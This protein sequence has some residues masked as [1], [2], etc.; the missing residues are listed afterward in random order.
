MTDIFEANQIIRDHFKE[1]PQEFK[2]FMKLFEQYKF[3]GEDQL[4]R[5]LFPIPSIQAETLFKELGKL[6]KT[7]L[8]F[9]QYYKIRVAKILEENVNHTTPVIVEHIMKELFG[10]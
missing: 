7:H 10:D 8:L 9:K 5:V 3:A 4:I 1:N 6:F 2:H